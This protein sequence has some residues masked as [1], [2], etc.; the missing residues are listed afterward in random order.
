MRNRWISALQGALLG[1]AVSPGLEITH[2]AQV[3]PIWAIASQQCPTLDPIPGPHLERPF[4]Q[5]TLEVLD[6]PANTPSL[7]TNDSQL[8]TTHQG[9]CALKGVV[10]FDSA[11]RLKCMEQCAKT[12]SQLCWPPEAQHSQACVNQQV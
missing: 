2:P 12:C 4:R 5:T 3:R 10:C 9:P 7:S 6:D 11:G 1:H 8:F